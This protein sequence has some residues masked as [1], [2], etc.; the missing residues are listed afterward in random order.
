M[1]LTK[2]IMILSVTTMGRLFKYMWDIF[3]QYFDVKSDNNY[4]TVLL[5]IYWW[6][7]SQ[8]IQKADFEINSSLLCSTIFYQITGITHLA[9]CGLNGIGLQL[10]F[11]IFKFNVNALRILSFQFILVP[12]TPEWLSSSVFISGKCK[13][14]NIYKY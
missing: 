8:K 2:Y 5:I 1:K 11:T 14:I 6:L 3:R 12:D 10:L 4:K 13:S 9:I 7:S